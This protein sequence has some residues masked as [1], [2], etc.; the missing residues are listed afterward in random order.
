MVPDWRFGNAD[1]LLP[2]FGREV[3][4]FWPFREQGWFEVEVLLCFWSFRLR[5]RLTR[6]NTDSQ[7]LDPCI[8]LDAPV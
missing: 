3:W 7:D 4:L 2:R 8:L 6:S 5:R 1:C